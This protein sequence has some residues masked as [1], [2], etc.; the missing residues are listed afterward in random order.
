LDGDTVTAVSHGGGINGFNTWIARIP[1]DE[2]LIVL[3][4]NTG[5]TDLSG[6][7]RQIMNILYE[8]PVELP[9]RSIGTEL[10]EEL[11]SADLESAVAHY[12][13]LREN[14]PDDFDFGETELNWLG[15]VLLEQDK[16]E[17]AIAIF[18]LNVEAYPESP[19][20][21]DSLGEAYMENGETEKAVE[22]YQRSLE[23][24]PE[25]SNA[26]EMLKKLRGGD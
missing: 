21:Y 26:V 3:L 22:N 13:D 11:E 20:V 6:M 5:G 16:I 7:S 12:R 1:E 17:E 14:R 24:D 4:N 25:N 2:N 23:L 8:K 10:L 19:N 15:Y 18:R 9:K